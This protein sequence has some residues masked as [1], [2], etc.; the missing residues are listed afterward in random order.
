M[1]EEQDKRRRLLEVVLDVASDGGS[2]ALLPHERFDADAIGAAISLAQ[3]FSA[4]GCEISVI[5]DEA[6]PVSMLHLPLL[7]SITVYEP[8]ITCSAFDLV[9]AIDCHEKNRLGARATCFSQSRLHGSIDHHVISSEL[10]ELDLVVSS[11]S[12]TC[13]LAFSII[14]DLELHLAK[15]LFNKEIAVLLLAGTITDTGRYAYSNTTPA[16][17]R[18]AAFLLERFA[19]DLSTLHYNL[20]ERTSVGRLQIKGDIFSGV[21]TYDDGRI[22]ASSVTREMLD[23]RGVADDDLAYFASDMRAAENSQVA[24]LFVETADKQG[25]RINIRSNG[26]FD[27]AAFAKRF[28]GGGHLRAAGMSLQNISIEQAMEKIISEARTSLNGCMGE[29]A[30]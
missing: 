11:A 29:I 2:I 14:W 20:Y 4:I 27:A 15:P 8:G 7:D 16:C 19:V 25:V 1:S 9:L 30:P 5:T 22:L 6:P 13:E 12:S 21:V 28:G 10:G 17:F 23:R 3:V 26:C 24:F 18:Q